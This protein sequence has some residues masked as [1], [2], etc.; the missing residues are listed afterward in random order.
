VNCIVE[1]ANSELPCGVDGAPIPLLVWRPSA[2]SDVWMCRSSLAWC[3]FVA[4]SA[5]STAFAALAIA[6]SAA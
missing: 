4:L 3:F 2:L 5:Y 1:N 6:S